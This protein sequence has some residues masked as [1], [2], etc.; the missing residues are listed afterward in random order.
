ML[1]CEE[2]IG[3]LTILLPTIFS[4]HIENYLTSQLFPIIIPFTLPCHH[5]VDNCIQFVNTTWGHIHT[6]NVPVC[7]H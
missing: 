2:Q 6:V 4:H 5:D 1:A 3:N 7:D